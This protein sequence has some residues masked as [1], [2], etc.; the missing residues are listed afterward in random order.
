[1]KTTLGLLHSDM[2]H[3]NLVGSICHLATSVVTMAPGNQWHEAVAKTIRRAKSG[4]ISQAVSVFFFFSSPCP[5]VCNVFVRPSTIFMNTVS[6]PQEERFSFNDDMSVKVQSKSIQSG[7]PQADGCDA[8][9]HSSPISGSTGIRVEGALLSLL[10]FLA[11]TSI[12][13]PDGKPDLQPPI[14]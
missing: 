7:N 13:G 4:K 14:V 8:E 6:C 3:R 12:G 9:V 1:M 11:R 5:F 10:V 2:H